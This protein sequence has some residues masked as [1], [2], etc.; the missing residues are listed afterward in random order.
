MLMTTPT[1]AGTPLVTH[2]HAYPFGIEEEYFVVCP[3]SKKL[4]DRSHKSL[5]AA[6]KRQLG[7]VVRS[8]MLR[9]QI[10]ISSPILTDFAQARQELR[11]ARG[12]LSE[13][14]AQHD[15]GLVA[16]GTYPMAA[17][18]EQRLTKHERYRQIHDELQI[19]GRRNVLC[20]MHVHVQPP[21]NASRVDL[22]NRVLPYLP[23]LLA[24]STSSPFWQTHRTGMKGYRLAAYDELPR[25]GLPPVF[26]N[27]G[28]YQLYLN[29]LT[30]SGAMAEASHIWWAI[31][32]SPRYPTLEL[33]I[34]DSCTHLEDSLCLAAIFRC[35]IRCLVN[36]PALNAT[37]DQMWRHLVDENR[38]R[39]QRFGTEGA[40]IDISSRS[41]LQ[42]VA[43]VV[44]ELLTLIGPDADELNCRT[45]VEHAR[46]ILRRGT[47]ADQQLRRYD[48]ARRDKKTRRA[49]LIDVVDWLLVTTRTDLPH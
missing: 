47:S 45:E 30:S 32:P 12:V 24:L 43:E 28:E 42:P 14:A 37:M 2:A 19:V 1:A 23:V 18:E 5:L 16:A 15:L 44:D 29:A 36:N 3:A 25:T 46:A 11:T 20:G 26:R 33:R 8:E 21:V 35:L 7:S 9:S 10:E 17:W 27:E 49:A 4:D 40:F 48:Q 22:M 34:A 38:W 13:I 31:R 39:A 6:C 41:R